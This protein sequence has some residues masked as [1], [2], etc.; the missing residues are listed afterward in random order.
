MATQSNITAAPAGAPV[1][2]SGPVRK[3]LAIMLAADPD[4][5]RVRE[6]RR[7]IA[8]RIEADI[9]LLDQLAGDPD[10]EEGGDLEPSLCG[11]HS[12]DG[13]IGGTLGPS[14]GNGDDREQDAG[15]EPELDESERELTLGWCEN[16]GQLALGSNTDDGD[17]TA[18]ESYGAGFVRS[19]HDDAEDGDN[20]IAD[21]DGKAEQFGSVYFGSVEELCPLTGQPLVLAAVGCDWR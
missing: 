8:D 2:A 15:D 12:G 21:S 3:A 7:S 11:S 19:G 18:L 14:T 1:R 5:V 4:Q 6:L 17:A 9:E 10:L 16:V 13:S 20:G